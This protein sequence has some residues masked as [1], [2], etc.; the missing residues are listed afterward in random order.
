MVTKEELQAIQERAEKATPGPWEWARFD[1]SKEPIEWLREMLSYGSGPVHGA[2]APGH[3]LTRG[4]HPRPEH[5]VM[6]AITGNGPTSEANAKFIA[7]ARTDVLALL[8]HIAAL[9]GALTPSAETK[10]AYSGEFQFQA[11]EDGTPMPVPWT[12][13]KEIMAAIRARAVL[14]R[15]P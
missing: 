4:T 12:T 7:A 14:G 13:I 8:E 6:P 1:D 11:D 3:P 5:A 2:W 9:E 10:G 15:E